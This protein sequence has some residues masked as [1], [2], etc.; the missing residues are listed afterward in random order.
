[1]RYWI[2]FAKEGELC[3][4]S[5]LDLQR[6]WQRCMR[7]AGLP[8]AYSA[9]F[10]PHMRLSF[11]SALPVGATSEAEYAE[12]WFAR[13]VAADEW[14]RLQEAMPEGFTLLGRREVPD[15]AASLMSLIGA[16]GWLVAVDGHEHGDL[17]AALQR[18]ISSVELPVVRNSKK[19]KKTVD[20]RPSI[21][22]VGLCG[23]EVRM[24]LK[25]GEG[26]GAKPQEVLAAA[27]LFAF[28]PVRR[29]GLYILAG[30]RLQSPLEVALNKNE[31]IINEQKDY[32]QL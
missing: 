13:P 22:N 14:Q 2:K 32:Y 4:I 5:H 23:R 31:V 1:M 27:G 28:Q 12:V 9:G 3:F 24:L 25:T 21:L 29:T 8:V 10:S 17:S 7:R 6:C 16:S 30:Q 18:L 11:A 15:G 26:G 19:G 20:L